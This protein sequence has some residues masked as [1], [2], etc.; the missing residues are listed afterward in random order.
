MG[1][2]IIYLIAISIFAYLFGSVNFAVI[3]SK[4]F[5]DADIRD[6]GSGNAGATNVMRTFGKKSGAVVFFLDFSKGLIAVAAAKCLVLFFNAPQECVFFAGFFA[7]LG[8]T[9]P[10]FFKFR[11]GKGVATAAGA[12][13]GIMPLTALILFAVFAVV[14]ALSRTVSLASALCAVLYPVLA[15]FLNSGN[16]ELF[17]AYAA[18][19]AVMIAVKHIPNII[20]II[21]GNENKI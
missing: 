1:D 3:V 10:L 5:F 21:D 4:K 13:L 14:L 20:R 17:F 7:Q 11:G 15:Y 8:H 2:I 12:A 16:K 19:C 9:F 6:H 18:A